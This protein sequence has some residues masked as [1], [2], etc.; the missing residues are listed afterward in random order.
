M[1]MRH[2]L[3]ASLILVACNQ[4]IDSDPL[5]SGCEEAGCDLTGQRCVANDAGAAV[6]IDIDVCAPNPC[7]LPGRSV[8]DSVNGEG[9]VCQCDDGLHED[10]AEGCTADPCLPDPCAG[11]STVCKAGS[12]PGLLCVCAP[13]YHWD[14][15][16]GCTDDPC[17][18]NPCVEPGRDVCRQAG[19]GIAVCECGQGF[20]EDGD[21]AAP[22]TLPSE[23]MLRPDP[24][25][26]LG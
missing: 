2:G 19:N 1:P 11:P 6:C 4:T 18:P 5:R 16:E 14:G 7:D 13:D 23:P 3:L 21:G 15:A 25:K 8:C 20:H 10:G 9:A 24:F 22:T 26:L 17:Q 12:G